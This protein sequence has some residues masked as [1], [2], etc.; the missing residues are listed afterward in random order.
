MDHFLIFQFLPA[1]PDP[2]SEGQH[3][4]K[5]NRTNP[6]VSVGEGGPNILDSYE[7]STLAS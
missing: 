3:P 2:N 7:E 1:A 6:N 5:Q 4:E